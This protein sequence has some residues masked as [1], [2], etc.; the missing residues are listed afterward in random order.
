MNGNQS[1]KVQNLGG[2]KIDNTHTHMYQLFY[3][4]HAGQRAFAG[5]LSWEVDDFVGTY[6]ITAVMPFTDGV[7]ASHREKVL[8]FSAMV[9]SVPHHWSK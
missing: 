5:C 9:I 7:Y 4:L 1:Q 6:I 3:S 8:E 2:E